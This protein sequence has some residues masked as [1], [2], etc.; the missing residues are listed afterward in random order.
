[1]NGEADRVPVLMLVHVHPDDESSLT[2][3]TIARYSAAKTRPILLACNDGGQG[4]DVADGRST[5]DRHR[6][7]QRRVRELRDAPRILGV[8]ELVELG[9]PDSGDGSR[10][11]AS[12]SLEVFGQRPIDPLVQRLVDVIGMHQ[13][14]VIVTHPPN[15]LSGQ[16]DNIRAHDI[17][18]AAHTKIIASAQPGIHADPSTLRTAG[19]N[20]VHNSIDDNGPAL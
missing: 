10:R 2:G 12:A 4:D 1:M 18:A 3:R 9:Y 20:T 7:A 6:V 16:P 17:V 14:D 19:S 5:P 11:S 13:P 15:G 8:H